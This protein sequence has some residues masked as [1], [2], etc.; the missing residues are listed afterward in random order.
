M[1]NLNMIFNNHGPQ[2]IE[3]MGYLINPLL[4]N[5]RRESNKLLVF[6]FHGLFNSL[7][8]KE[9]NHIDPQNNMTVNQFSDFIEYFLSKNYKFIR[10]EDLLS[11]LE[12]NQRYAMITFDDGYFNN[13]LA[14][15]ILC[16]YKIPAV[17][18]MTTNNI[19]ENKSF[20]WDI[21]YRNRTEKGNSPDTIHKEQKYLKSLKYSEIE[22]YIKQNFGIHSFSPWSDIDRPFN[23]LELAQIAKSPYVVIGNHTHNHS[24]L[25]NYSKEEIIGEIMESNKFLF[26]L[27]GTSPIT[28][29]F[30][31][32]EY[33][34]LVLA[35]TEE[36]GFRFAFTTEPKNN[37]FPTEHH[38]MDTL[39]RFMSTNKVDINRFGSFYRLGYTPTVLYSSLKRQ[40]KGLKIFNSNTL[41]QLSY[42]NE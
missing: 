38:H 14:F 29:A 16:R 39:G 28:L 3:N 23:P 41:H 7:K 19:K 35:T 18:F 13:M 26:D 9:F 4:L 34:K 8:Q 12:D 40:I 1:Q 24:I 20:W 31:N 25:T 11:G 21:I 27:T 30:P 17:F 6:G 10:P 36:A 37:L 33:N 42:I 5:F 2:L 32:G 22:N 15:E